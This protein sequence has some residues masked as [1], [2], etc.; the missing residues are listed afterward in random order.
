MDAQNFRYVNQSG[1]ISIDGT[2]DAIELQENM[3][4]PK[5]ALSMLAH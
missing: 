2:D 4:W 3:V 1:C 5:L